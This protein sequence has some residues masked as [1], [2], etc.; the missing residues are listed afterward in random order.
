MPL[1]GLPLVLEYSL[2][3]LLVQN[4][5][6]SWQI[7]GGPHFSQVSIRFQNPAIATSQVD[8]VQYRRAPPSRINRD[9]ERAKQKEHEAVSI[10]GTSYNDAEKTSTGYQYTQ[11]EQ[12]NLNELLHHAPLDTDSSSVHMQC[13]QADSQHGPE[14][15]LA[16][17]QDKAVLPLTGEGTVSHDISHESSE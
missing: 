17:C 1:E 8:E 6:S 4:G 11:P 12:I 7:R 2:K 14:S 15:I 13:E 3:G 9:R 16:A 10:S 5:I